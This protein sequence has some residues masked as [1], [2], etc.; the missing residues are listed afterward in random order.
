MDGPLAG[1]LAA[2]DRP[3]GPERLPGPA[4]R[5]DIEGG[6]E[7]AEGEGGI[8][9]S[10]H[11]LPVTKEGP[12][13]ILD[14]RGGISDGQPHPGLSEALPR[15]TSATH[16][17]SS[18]CWDGGSLDFQ[19]GSPPPHLLG[20][21]P[22]PPDGQGTWEHPLVQEA[23]EGIPSERRFE[24]S[25]IVRTL[26][27]HIELEG[28][29]RFLHHQGETK[30]LE[31]VPRGHPRFDWLRDT[32]EQAPPQDAELHL[33]L[34]P[35]PLPLTSFRTVLVPVEDT[36]K[37]LDVTVVDTR[38]H[39]ADLEGLAQPS[40]WGL[41]RSASEVATQTWTVNSEASVERLQP[42][43]PPIRTGPYLCELLEEVAKGVA[44]PDE[45]E[46]EE[47]A[48]FPCIEC[49]IY[50]KQKEHLLE[51]MSQHRR[52]PG[53]EPPADLALPLAC[54]ECG[55][56][57]A[58]PGALEQH[59][60]LHQASREKIIEE[61]QKLK[62]VPPGDEGREARLQC[63]K[64]I[65][66]T[67]SSKAFVQHAKLHVREPPGQPARKPFG[68]GSGAG[69]PGP[70][71][72]TLTYRSYRASSGLRGCVFCGF[73]APS[74][75]LLREHMR[76]AH[77][78][79]HWEDDAEA[80][81]EDP[82]SQPG[83]SQDAYARFPDAAEDYFG[84]AEPLL[85]PS[86][87]EN[88][89][90]YDPSLAFGPGCQQLGM[91]DFPLS[92]PLLHGSDQRLPGR[93]AFP[94]PLASAPYS[95]QPSRNKSVVPPQGLPAQL[96]DRRHPWSEEEEDI[97]LASEMDFSPENGVFPPLAAPSLIPQ[98][99][100]DL[101]RT[102]RKALRAAE[103]SRAQQ[104]QLRGMVPLVLVAKLGP[105]V[106]AAVTR[107]PPRLQPEELGLGGAHPL[108]FLLLEAP[109]G[110]PLGLDALLD[111]DPA[112]ALKH[113]ERK[114]PYCPD[115]FHNGIGLANHV[116]GHLNRVGVSYNVRHFI[117]AEEV[118]A[119]ERRFSFQKK[120]KKVANFDPGTFSLMRCDFCGA[121]FDTRAGLS[122]HARAHLRDF[123]ITNWEL[124][125]SPINILQELLATSAAERPPSPLGCEPG[126]SPSGFLTSRR[127][128]LPLA[129]PFPPTWAEDPGPAYGDAQSLTTCEVC[130]ACFETRKGL[131]SHA[132]SHLRQ[133]GVAE[134]ES[135]G[136]PIDLLYE[137][138]KQKG[139]PDTP[140]GLP[141]GLSK[142]SNSPKE[143]V[144]GAPRPGLLALAK[145]LDAPAVNKAIKSPPG[146][147]TKGLAHPPSSPLL[148]KAP[149][150]LAGSPTPKNPEDK[151]PQLSLSP[152]PAS[153]KAQWPQSEDEGP[154]NLTSGPEPAR[155]I[156][157]EFCGEFFENRKGLSSHARSHL[158]QMGVTEWYVNG[159]P[160]DTLREI[161]KRRTQSRPGG[162]ANP[163][164]PSPK[165]LAKVVGSG[166][167]GSSLEARSPADL[168]L[169]PLAKKLPPPP[170]S[171]LG[172]SP[173][174]SPPPTARKMFPGLAAPSLPKKLKPEQMRVEI[175]REMLPGALHGEPHPSEGPWAAPREDMAPLNLSSR[176]EPVRDI[177]CEFCGEFFENRKGLSSHARSHLRQMGV[178]EWSVNGSP[179]DTLREIL[180]KK[181]KP[182][183]IKKEPPA[184]DLAPA[185]AEDGPPTAAPGP[186]QAPLPLAPMAGRPGKPGAGPAQVPRELSLAPIT[187]AKPAATGY[188]GSVAAKRPLQEDR[189]L[190]AEVKAKT[191]I[192]TELP[193]K[194]KTLHEKTSHS[195]TE[196]CCELCG[197]YFENRKALASHARAHLRQFGVTE[198]CVNGSPIE[199]LSEWIK[200]RPQKVG[201]YRS[202]IQGG[203]PFTKKFRSAG[204]GRDSD[205][206]PPLGL[207]PGG[208]AVVGRSAGGEPGPEAGRAADSGERPLA[209]SPP[210]TVKAEEHQR[211]NIN[212]FERRQARP[213]DAS[214]VRGGEEANDLQQKLE[215]VRQPP[216]RVRPVPS[217]VPRPPQTSL[218]KFVGNIYTLKCRFCEVE[219]QGPL[220]IQEEWVRHLQR[221]ILEMNFSKADPPPEE[222]RA[223]QAQTAAA[224]AP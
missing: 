146:F 44:S 209:A 105:Q 76:L 139:L 55:W 13:D 106:M 54:G 199:T 143:V 78:Q 73:P 88:P 215:E 129:V 86:W 38:E 130:G 23:R 196:A 81:E 182:C 218:V 197:L 133:L 19:P 31:K 193:F 70:D 122:S 5:E 14:G 224:D 203:R 135:S 24:D 15:A 11:Y 180:K 171:P 10:T 95:L 174:A 64:C 147:S 164:G 8:F 119:I 9:R 156:R 210:G 6:A 43:L 82:A 12:Q 1:G 194:A 213:P 108:D 3:R 216:P 127:P 27:P 99:A 37:T 200:H 60:Q 176:A 22:G 145:P 120:K 169:S 149:L 178:T 117:S 98:L 89:A 17:I 67:N 173:T 148:K 40:E 33:D 165:A 63:P 204:H 207:A 79:P 69:S 20:H 56:A 59:R 68:S 179:I 211:Q 132:R 102:F 118:K 52:A 32:D 181:S 214:A 177:R 219:F 221:H 160:I 163:P 157:C 71:A 90:G 190:P 107:V 85:A 72:T 141:P 195:S 26:K 154:L 159:S 121:G 41:P 47:P 25:V 212:K 103:A 150:A 109:L 144:A 53:Q 222:P 75:S 84:K 198:W 161:L 136:A 126:G 189:L 58:D 187:G 184:G 110:G 4:P 29:R 28:S 168:H 62:Q 155:D 61:I 104:Q 77:A 142:K 35:Q 100:L 18:C 48:V 49:S 220:S 186:V 39:L 93:P 183:L 158:R 153:P 46:D 170:G 131:S 2:P 45:D 201:A 114:C 134:S 217:L 162:P 87:Q 96:G 7:A 115:R 128:R 21:F 112:V 223:L 80:F 91:R 16:R 57:F 66:G 166:G 152:R 74:E 191:Y 192:Q 92:K 206:R 65:F 175:K 151:S 137:L 36:T 94:S 83:T 125:V 185:L 208:L 97:P 51:H 50:F 140:L 124:T 116:R 167:P 34:P 30:L 138:V 113:E 111:E 172:H 202:Y 42:L 123:G 101:K 205:K 188:L